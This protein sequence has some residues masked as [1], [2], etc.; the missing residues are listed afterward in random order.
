MERPLAPAASVV[1]RCAAPADAGRDGSSGGSLDLMADA[2]L[3]ARFPSGPHPQYG[4][5]RQ[6]TSLRSTAILRPTQATSA[7]GASVKI[8]AAAV[9][10]AHR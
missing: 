8:A 4:R 6:P 10:T 3:P 7:P 1:G 5:W 9:P 2:S